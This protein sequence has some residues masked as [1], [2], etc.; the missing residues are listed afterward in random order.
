M[1]MVWLVK[2]HW[3]HEGSEVVSVWTVAWDAYKALAKLKRD[4][5]T[6]GRG[7]E[8]YSVSRFEVD[9]RDELGAEDEA[10]N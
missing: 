9:L 5:D 7:F 1:N 3:M 6:L 8:F 4:R 10:N 2:G